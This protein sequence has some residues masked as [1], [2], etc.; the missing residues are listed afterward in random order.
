MKRI[1]S[2]LIF[3]FL[4]LPAAFSQLPGDFV[5]RLGFTYEISSQESWGKNR[6]VVLSV[7]PLSPADEAGLKINDVIESIN[8][9]KTEGQP[10][11]ALNGM[12]Q[13]NSLDQLK[14][15]VRNLGYKDKGVNLN[16]DCKLSRALNERDLSMVYSFYSLEDMQLRGF[17]CP[18]RTTLRASS[19][20]SNYKT[21]GFMPVDENNKAL[22]DVINASIRKALEKRGL[23]YQAENPDL[24]IST[25]YSYNKNKNFQ[26]DTNVDKLPVACRYNMETGKMENLPIYYHP[27]IGDKQAQYLLSLGI[28]LIDRSRSS[29]NNLHVIWECEANELLGS[30]YPLDAYSR[31]HIPLML[32]Q[33]PYPQT[34]GEARFRYNSMKYNYTGLNYNIDNLEEVIDVDRL[35]P[36]YQS[37]LKPGDQ[38][39]R[40]CGIKIQPDQTTASEAYKQFIYKTIS[41]RDPK[42]TYTDANGF[43]QCMFWNRLN[44]A[45]VSDEFKNPRYATAYSY[46]FYFEPYINLSGTNILTFDVK[47]G[48]ERLSMKVTPVI[49]TESSFENYK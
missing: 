11:D 13:N 33:Y 20:F 8:G 1:F 41:L 45:Q 42:T 22:E 17:S 34:L 16:K 38:I 48:R 4:I 14:L 39:E 7:Q 15:V 28:Q 46:L 29:G 18:F 26:E 37:S 9:V 30:D 35:S 5:C 43:T 21:F 36:A 6:P 24:A 32:M 23:I 27:L 47:R 44:Y 49:R 10:I 31:L 40:I 12:F 2:L 25:N 19:D 3:S